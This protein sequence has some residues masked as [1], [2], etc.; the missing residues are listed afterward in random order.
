MKNQTVWG[1]YCLKLDTVSAL[2][3]ALCCTLTAA[4][5]ALQSLQQCHQ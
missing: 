3:T 5:S 2:V 1:R 4:P